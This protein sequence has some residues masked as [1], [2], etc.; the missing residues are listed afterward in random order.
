[1][2]PNGERRHRGTALLCQIGRH[3]RFLSKGEKGRVE[4]AQEAKKEEARIYHVM[5]LGG[6]CRSA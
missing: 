6:T 4:K 2:P 5:V 3:D 1:M